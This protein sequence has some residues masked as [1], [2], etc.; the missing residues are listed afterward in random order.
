LAS[1]L[2]R[3]KDVTSENELMTA[4]DR[5]CACHDRSALAA[6]ASRLAHRVGDPLHDQL[7]ELAMLCWQDFRR[8]TLR[9]AELSA[10]VA[11]RFEAA[12]T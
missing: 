8:A 4:G 1:A 9:W 12:G 3:V 10:H 7:L 11:H 2:L 6:I 5:A